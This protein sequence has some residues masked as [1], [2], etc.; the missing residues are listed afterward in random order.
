[1]GSLTG[2]VAWVTGAGSG[3][4]QAAAVALAMERFGRLDCRSLM[5]SG[6]KE[7]DR[8]QCGADESA[9]PPPANPLAH[10]RH[11]DALD[12][13]FV[14]AA[15]EAVTLGKQFFLGACDEHEVAQVFQPLVHFPAV[16]RVRDP[17]VGVHASQVERYRIAAQGFVAAPGVVLVKVGHDEFA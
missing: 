10:A 6:K 14:D 15:L 1:M 16:V 4:G 8:Q 13:D 5:R 7:V 17:Q 3:I 2:K 11:I 12:V 9:Q